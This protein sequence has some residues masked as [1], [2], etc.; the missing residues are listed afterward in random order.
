MNQSQQKLDRAEELA[1]L[2]RIPQALEIL[3]PL[4]GDN[5]ADQAL[6]HGHIGRT[7][8]FYDHDFQQ[9]ESHARSAL[10]LNPE[11]PIRS[12]CLQV[13]AYSLWRQGRPAEALQPLREAISLDPEAPSP[14]SVIAKVYADLRWFTKARHEAQK[15]IELG[16]SNPDYHFSLGYV[17]HDVDPEAAEL[18]YR[19]A[20]ELDPGKVE[21][22]ENIAHLALKRGDLRTASSGLIEVLSEAPEDHRPVLILNK[23]VVSAIREATWLTLPAC[24]LCTA[25]AFWNAIGGLVLSVLMVTLTVFRL[26]S[27]ILPLRKGAGNSFLKGFPRREKI[28]TAWACLIAFSWTILTGSLLIALIFLRPGAQVLALASVPPVLMGGVLDLIRALYIRKSLD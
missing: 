17:L 4:L 5:D 13:L 1:N 19:K 24:L 8:L 28:A 20:L 26:R 11:N 7:H 16:P 14:H 23:K 21:A 15:A 18:A 6:V 22:K 2:G 25:V 12:F 3:Y 27:R 9:A 10:A